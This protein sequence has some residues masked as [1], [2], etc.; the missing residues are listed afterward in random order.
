MKKYILP[1][2]MCLLTLPCFGQYVVTGGNALLAKDDQTTKVYLL[3]G[4]SGAEI[5]YTS[6]N[7]VTH[8]WYKYKENTGS[9]IPIS[10]NQL[11]GNMSV[12]TNL[13][14]GWGYYVENSADISIH[15][16]WIIDYSTKI[17]VLK[18][19]KTD[20]SEEFEDQC[21]NLKLLIDFDETK[22]LEYRTPSGTLSS[23]VRN[24]V[25][26]YFTMAW[27]KDHDQFM[28]EPVT[29][30]I[31]LRYEHIISA[32]LKNTVFTL[33]GDQFAKLLG[34]KEEKIETPEYK[35]INVQAEIV[36]VNNDVSTYD[37]QVIGGDS[38]SAPANFTFTAQAN[39]PVATPAS[40][41]WEIYNLNRS[42]TNPV[43]QIRRVKELNYT[44]E[45]AGRYKVSLVV[46]NSEST[47]IYSTAI[48]DIIVSDFMLWVPNAFSPTSS[49]GV[50]DVFKVAYK[51]VITFN[52]WI[53]N[54]W[55]NEI[56]RWS[57][58]SQGWDGKYQGKYVP[59]GTYFYV[60]EATDA[61]GKKHVKKGDVN[62]VGGRR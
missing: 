58:P 33:T 24:Y 30:E 27:N 9:K 37:N 13:E 26:K 11:T 36:A 55:G 42:T 53:F 38:I 62:I 28:D 14:D 51:S 8:Q 44:F 46:S 50:N 41:S 5:S 6:P 12:I 17:P 61:N 21:E 34:I 29:N 7:N 25:L 20:N 19:L 40:Y 35:A 32:P 57:D 49:P 1:V 31:S 15:Y 23:I 59:P 2:F 60:I 4:L 22:K 39:E 18:S 3:N 45:N 43:Y 54:R 47:C 56:F 48:E 10:S 16:L 52:G